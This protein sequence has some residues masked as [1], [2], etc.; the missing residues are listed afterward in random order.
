MDVSEDDNNRQERKRSTSGSESKSSYISPNP[1]QPLSNLSEDNDTETMDQ[2]NSSNEKSIKPPPIYVNKS[3]INVILS[4]LSTQN[5]GNF[6]QVTLD[7]QRVKFSFESV[8]GYRNAIKYFE[9]N[10]AENHTFQLKN[11]RSFRVVIRGLHPSCDTNA[12]KNELCEQGFEPL[13]MLPIYHH[14]TKVVRLPLFFLDLKP[15]VHNDNIYDLNRLYYAVIKV[16]PPKPKRHIIQCMKCQEYGHSKN[17]CNKR[18]RCV[19]CDGIHPTSNCNKP[20]NVPPACVN[21]KG[22]HTASYRGCPEH[23]KLQKATSSFVYKRKVDVNSFPVGTIVPSLK[24]PAANRVTGPLHLNVCALAD[25]SSGVRKGGSAIF[26]KSDL[27]HGE[28]L[29]IIEPEIQVARIQITFE[30]N[31][32]Q[33]ASFYS[34]PANRVTMAQIWDITGINI[35]K[36]HFLIGGDIPRWGSNTTNPREA[37]VP[38]E[39]SSDH[40]PVMIHLSINNLDAPLHPTQ[41]K[42]PFNW[43]LYSSTLEAITETQIPLKTPNDVDIAVSRLTRNIQFAANNNFKGLF[44]QR[45]LD[46]KQNTLVHNNFIGSDTILDTYEEKVVCLG[47]FLDTEKAFDKVW[48]EGLLSKLKNHVSD[49]YYLIIKSYLS[50]RTFSVKY[51]SAQSK[52]NIVQS[53]VPQ[54]SLHCLYTTRDL[55]IPIS[56]V[57]PVWQYGCSIWGSASASQIRRIQVMQNRYLRLMS[58]A[59]WYISNKNLHDDLCIPESSSLLMTPENM[60]E[61]CDSLMISFSCSSPPIESLTHFFYRLSLPIQRDVDVL[62]S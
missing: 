13:Q 37:S 57:R 14:I 31:E 48:H 7:N 32:L 8:E 17:Y 23:L 22:Q 26:I 61:H 18:A 12:V 38:H 27:K 43:Q 16:D 62:E 2:N 35:M 41:M 50:Q 15:N 60:I 21:C 45:S 29:P 5:V 9:T 24:F 49:S 3:N 36:T 44:L 51:E 52:S 42:F 54:G 20:H 40:L 56:I 34:A 30:G 59:P 33:I 46:L 58:G 19:K 55:S 10:K 6:K 4:N 39:L 25:H 53:G 1:F 28:L 47:L 11:E